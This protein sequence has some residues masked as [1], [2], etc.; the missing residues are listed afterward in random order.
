MMRSGLLGLVVG[1]ITFAVSIAATFL[2]RRWVLRRF[3]VQRKRFVDIVL[4]G[5]A[6]LAPLG[7][8]LVGL[9][10]NDRLAWIEAVGLL[11]ALTILVA[12]P[13]I[14]VFDAV[15]SRAVVPQR[16]D[17]IARIG[18]T[19]VVAAAG[20]P[21]ARGVFTRFD[22]DVVE[23]PVR[24][25]KLP[26]ALDGFTIVQVSDIHIGAYLG[27]APLRSAEDVVAR[28]KPDLVAMT[29]DLVHLRPEYLPQGTDWVRRLGARA[30]HGVLSILGNHEYY[31]GRVDV[32]EAFRRAGLELLINDA[33][34]IA[35]I[36]FAGIDDAYAVKRGFRQ[37]LAGA[38]AKL[39]DDAPRILLAHHPTDFEFAAGKVDLQLSG[40]TH[41]G[42]IAPLGPV[43][44][45]VMFRGKCAG[46]YRSNGSTLYVNRGF[47]TSGPP[48]RVAVRPEITKIVL[49]AG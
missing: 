29:G 48:S 30:R 40:H 35:G 43:V 8:S 17:A 12:V 25:A 22:F 5:L 33:R 3:A 16:R 13:V 10:F 2:L 24:I 9:G 46:I 27:E 39:R 4:F 47:G 15:L 7:R 38:L 31:V 20:V 34:L 32:L 37:D 21:L 44:A 36:G 14:Y 18:G 1:L 11:W 28:F 6:A 23:L 41:G 45:N 49:V 26:R 42:Q 19:V